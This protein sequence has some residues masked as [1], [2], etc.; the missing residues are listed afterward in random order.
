VTCKSVHAGADVKRN[1]RPKTAWGEVKEEVPQCSGTRPQ[2]RK[3]S[4]ATRM[5]PIHKSLEEP[6]IAGM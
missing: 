3:E 2:S 1:T 6:K 5:P 4:G